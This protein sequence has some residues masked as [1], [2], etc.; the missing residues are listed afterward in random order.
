MVNY[1]IN[2]ESSKEE[3]AE[4][5]EN[6]IHK[7]FE[8]N[9]GP[10]FRLVYTILKI[11]KDDAYL[12]EDEKARYGNLLRSQLTSFEVALH[13]LNGLSGISKD[14]GKLICEFHLLKYLPEGG[15]RIVLSK[16]YPKSAFASRDDGDELFSSGRPNL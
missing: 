16:C 2:A 5:Y 3:I 15:R 8:N 6:R 7:R 4:V 9:F 10:Y 1:Y 13:G 14:F 11:I 12:D